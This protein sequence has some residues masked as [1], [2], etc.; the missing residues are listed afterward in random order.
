MSILI[1]EVR[2]LHELASSDVHSDVFKFMKRFEFQRDEKKFYERMN[3]D[4][5]EAKKQMQINSL[6]A[7]FRPNQTHF[8]Q[9]T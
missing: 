3:K 2:Y 7:N 4:Y 9:L 6:Y 8:L 5:E 1:A